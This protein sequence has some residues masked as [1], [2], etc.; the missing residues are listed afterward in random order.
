MA[1]LGFSFQPFARAT[2]K[3]K[4]TVPGPRLPGLGAPMGSFRGGV[5]P[6]QL[7]ATLEEGIA[8]HK[9][10]RREEAERI[11][12]SVLQK[13]PGQPDALNLLGVLAGEV[14]SYDLA[15]SLMQQ[16][17]QVRPKEPSVLNN[18]GNTLFK[19]HRYAEAVD[20]FERALSF[21]PTFPEALINLGRSLRFCDR[22]DEA[23]LAFERHIEVKGPG[24]AALAGI[25]RVLMD[26][27]KFLEAEAMAR[28]L[29]AKY[30]EAPAGFVT[31]A[32]ARKA[33]A[34]D[35]EISIVEDLIEKK[36]DAVKD[37]R[38]LYY[39]AGKMCDDVG[40]YDEAFRYFDIANKSSDLVH[41]QDEVVARRSELMNLFAKEFFRQR[42][43]YGVPSE[44]PVFIVGMPRS[45]TTLCEQVLSAHPS[46]HGA[47]ELDSIGRLWRAASDLVPGAAPKWPQALRDMT[48]FA[49]ETLANRYLREL[50]DHSR[51]A[52]RVINKMPH[53]FEHLGFIQLLFPKAKIIHCRRE[54]LD[55]CLSIWT[56]NFNDGHSY[57]RD[58]RDLGYYYREYMRLMDYWQTTLDLPILEVVYEDMIANQESVSRRIIDF[59]GLQ[60]DP[61]CLEFHKVDRPVMTASSWQVRQPLYTGSKERWRNY[62]RHLAPLREGLEDN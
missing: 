54:P 26:Q 49:V 34:D 22:H 23:K 37:L 44:R 57:A 59:V 39:A 51:T 46:I 16:A 10:G 9:A 41:R 45:G 8:H 3:T 2:M 6:F 36:K 56:Q 24:P 58:L 61:R 43:T 52:D 13:H 7:Q 53:N 20:Y 29:I 30:P 27:G 11:Y 15:I 50:N 55:S 17:A 1:V 47:G 21:S 32:N 31:L 14:G 60:W 42:K 40:R 28:D 12:R 62:D 35:P 4:P 18:I 25:A 48:W 38:G 19:V 5:D 33:K